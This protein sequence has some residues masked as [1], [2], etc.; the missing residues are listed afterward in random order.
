DA[1]G[2]AVRCTGRGELSY[3]PA[4][5]TVGDGPPRRVLGSAGP[6]VVHPTLPAKRGARPTARLQVV[7]EG[8]DDDLALLLEVAVGND[9]Q[10]T[11]EGIYD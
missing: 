1:V 3:P 8:E 2:D 7:L 10:W 6:W 11:V 4:T 5:V 9:P